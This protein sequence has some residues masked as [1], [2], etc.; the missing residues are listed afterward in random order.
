M[1]TTEENITIFTEVFQQLEMNKLIKPLEQSDELIS[2]LISIY[3]T[4]KLNIV[5]AYKRLC[6][7]GLKEAKDAVDNYAKLNEDKI[8][9][10]SIKYEINLLVDKA[11]AID[12]NFSI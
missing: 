3:P 10:I 1:N 4:S 2:F 6:G 8:K 7:I 12:P 11:L 9:L 5:R